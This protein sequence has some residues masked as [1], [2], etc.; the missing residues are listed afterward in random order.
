MAMVPQDSVIFAASARDNLRYGKWDASDEEIWAAARAANA[1]AFLRALPQGLDSH[2]GEGGARLSGGQRQRVSIAR[3]LLRDAPILLLDEATVGLDVKSRAEV[4]ALT[5]RLIAHLSMPEPLLFIGGRGSDHNT[6]ERIRGFRA[7][8]ADAGISVR[9]DLILPCGYAPE[10]AQQALAAFALQGQGLPPA[11]FI[12]STI[13]LEGVMG[14]IK[15]VHRDDRPDPMIGCF[16]WDPLVSVLAGNIPMVRQDVP[17]MLDALFRVID[18]GESAPTLIQI[19][20]I[21]IPA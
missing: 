16:D 12:N 13:T 1:E 17:G 8:H 6:A 7:A 2:L 9:D 10:K 20:T 21:G 19:P 15:S 4:L 14:W 3:A 18:T 11:L 5:R